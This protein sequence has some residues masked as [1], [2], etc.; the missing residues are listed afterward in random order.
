MSILFLGE[1]DE[2]EELEEGEVK[3]DEDV[4]NATES[5]ENERNIIPTIQDNQ[6]SLS[7]LDVVIYS[8]F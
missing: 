5:N 1:L 3:E 8:I 6:N 4:N 2:D 7:N